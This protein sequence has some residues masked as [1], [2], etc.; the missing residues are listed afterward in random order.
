MIV[1]CNVDVVVLSPRQGTEAVK[2]GDDGG[3][4]S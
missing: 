2:L 4:D 3:E 1:V